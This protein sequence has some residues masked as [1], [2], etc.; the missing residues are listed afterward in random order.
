MAP[1]AY[2]LDALAARLIERLEPSRRTHLEDEAAT[3]ATIEA[4]VEATVAAQARECRELTG[5]VAQAERIEREGLGTFLPRYLRLAL[6][7]NRAEG[8]RHWF[9]SDS[10][11]V[12]FGVV[13][14]A[15]VGATVLVEIL[16][17]RGDLLLYLLPFVALVAPEVR[18][19]QHRRRYQA[20]LQLLVDDL[21]KVQ[22]AEERLAPL[23]TD[24][25]AG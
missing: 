10:L 13:L 22:E 7:Q 20:E 3:R 14:A 4:L 15:F 23:L 25:Q 12:R 18:R 17:V 8:A 5:D 24:D 19:W 11:L 9:W 16:P 1:D 21:G 6:A 2:R